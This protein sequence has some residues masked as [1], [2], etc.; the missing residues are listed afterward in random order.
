M[1]SKPRISGSK[2]NKPEIF[3]TEKSG[4]RQD[5]SNNNLEDIYKE[6]NKRSTKLPS[7]KI[8]KYSVLT[9]QQP[10]NMRKQ[11]SISPSP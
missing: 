4:K 11:S 6:D 5:S 3:K 9:N 2:D 7:M 1:F 8:S 10:Q